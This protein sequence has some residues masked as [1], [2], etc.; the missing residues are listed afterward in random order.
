MAK[1]S[2]SGKS[3]SMV[4]SPA[5]RELKCLSQSMEGSTTNID[6]SVHKVMYTNTKRKNKQQ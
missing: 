1:L 2:M 5:L 4:I 3:D 6:T